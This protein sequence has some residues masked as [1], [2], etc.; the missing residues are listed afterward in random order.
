MSLIF[1]TNHPQP[2]GAVPKYQAKTKFVH[3]EYPR[4]T[5][6]SLFCIQNK[7]KQLLRIQQKN[8]ALIIPQYTP[9]NIFVCRKI[10]RL[11]LNLSSVQIRTLDHNSQVDV[12][13]QSAARQQAEQQ[14]LAPLTLVKTIYLNVC[15][16]TLTANKK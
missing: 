11:Q 4:R 10:I 14:P 2:V 7:Q 8:L 9:A 3:Q 16:R 1:S 5:R 15:L 12:M 13:L 6:F